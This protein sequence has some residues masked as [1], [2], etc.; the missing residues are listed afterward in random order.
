MIWSYPEV[1]DWEIGVR[2]GSERKFF[3]FLHGIAPPGPKKL[4]F[5]VDIFDAVAASERPDVKNILEKL[6]TEDGFD[7]EFRSFD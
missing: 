7:I 2:I 6:K 3:D 4:V 5:H 1:C